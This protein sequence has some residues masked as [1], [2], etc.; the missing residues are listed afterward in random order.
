MTMNDPLFEPIA[1]GSLECKNRIYLPA[2]HMNMTMDFTVTDLLT[3]FYA[4]RARGG[5]GMIAV[6]FATI[7]KVAGG[8]MNIGA[9][10][11]DFLPGLEKLARAIGEG[12]ARSVIQLNHAGRYNHSFFTAGEQ[13]VAPSPIAPP[14]A[15]QP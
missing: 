6:G 2:M 8:P 12:G 10:D 7:N 13:P 11:D 3:D 4:E 5:A 1:I 15:H 9:H 14:A